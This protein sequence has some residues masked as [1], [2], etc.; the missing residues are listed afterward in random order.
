MIPFVPIKL[1]KVYNLR[2]GMGAAYEFEKLTGIKVTKIDLENFSITELCQLLWVML[3]REKPEI[4]LE[5]TLALVDENAD[6]MAKVIEAITG[7]ITAAFVEQEAAP[8][9]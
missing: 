9:A 4:T 2:F 3:R 7:A 5:Q 8:N 6:S 1:D